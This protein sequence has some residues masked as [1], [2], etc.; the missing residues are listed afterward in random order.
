V[1]RSALSNQAAMY[2][3]ERAPRLETLR[4]LF[5]DDP[6]GRPYRHLE[7]RAYSGYFLRFAGMFVRNA[8][9]TLARES[10]QQARAH[11]PACAEDW[12]RDGSARLTSFRSQ[13]A[14][15]AADCTRPE[16]L[17][18]HL[19][20]PSRASCD[21][22]LRFL[23]EDAERLRLG[24]LQYTLEEPF[25]LWTLLPALGITRV[26]LFG[27][28]GWGLALYRQLASAGVSCVAV[29]DNNAST[30]QA[31]MIPVPYCSLPEYLERLPAVDA[32]VSS[33]QGDHDRNVLADLQATLPVPVV[34]WKMLFA[35][36]R[37]QPAGVLDADRLVCQ[38]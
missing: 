20:T 38:E 15:S 4:R 35:P 19:R 33:L 27:G 18:A 34:S 3:S 21:E 8:D 32:V 36:L 31:A 28:E 6:A 12:L 14:A 9:W 24:W 1:D 17:I 29:I 11:C 26:A 16:G 30:R 5:H 2:T 25:N 23:P 7:A 37:E 10:Y 22:A 13:L